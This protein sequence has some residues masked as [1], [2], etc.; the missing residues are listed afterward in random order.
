MNFSLFAKD[1]TGVELLLFDRAD[2]GATP[3]RVI[4]LDPARHR[5]YHYWHAFVP[6]LRPGQ[7]YAIASMGRST[8][9]TGV[10]FDP[11][12]GAA[13]SV[14]TGAWPSRGYRPRGGERGA[15]DNAAPR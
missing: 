13:R 14:R 7:I 12:E 1:A 6:G 5:T 9:R 15:G 3:S 11:R 8:R 10:R 4:A 2:D